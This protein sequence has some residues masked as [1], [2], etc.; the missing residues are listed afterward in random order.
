M[1]QVEPF[2]ALP[3]GTPVERIRIAGGG[4]TAH[5]LTYGAVLQDLRLAGVD[6][7]LVLGAED[8][9]A[10]LGP[11]TWFG[12]IVGRFANR[13]AGGRLTID[14]RIHALDRNE[15][16]ATCLHGGAE[17]AGRRVWR[18]EDLTGSRVVLGLTDPDG[19]MGFPGTVEIRTVIDLPGEGALSF[20][21]TATTDAPTAV[22]LAHH[23]YFNLDDSSDIL[24]HKLWI[25]AEHFTP[26][27][28]S[29]IP[30]GVS[31]VGGTPF[32]FRS[33]RPVAPGG[34]DHNFCLSD[35]AQP[36]REVARLTGTTGVS[37]AIETTAP[38]LQ[39]YDGGHISDL[40][41]LG[42]R[43]HGPHAGIALETQVWPD[44]PNQTGFPEWRLDPGET[45]RHQ[46][47]YRF[48]RAR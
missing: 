48:Q 45:Y 15:A 2:G 34:F 4:L 14:G 30:T 13:I 10:Y 19:H 8:L 9:A 36:L 21:I 41:G 43:L 46:V 35:A 16:G 25:D 33:E 22:S 38:G 5:V 18:I 23:G 40:P 24:G 32:D 39:V 7:P 29:L 47:I 17:G 28:R 12:A 26:V 37:M 31:P 6:H 42:G 27:D 20:D 11:M 3:D 44:A 1:A